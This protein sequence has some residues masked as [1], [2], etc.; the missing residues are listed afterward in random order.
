MGAVIEDDH[1]IHPLD[2]GVPGQPIGPLGPR[3]PAEVMRNQHTGGSQ[4]VGSFATEQG[5]QVDVLLKYKE[6]RQDGCH[7]NHVQKKPRQ[8]FGE[9][10][11]CRF[12]DS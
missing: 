5:V 7:Q 2:F 3:H 4:T 10:G 8:D 9:Q 11:Q 12:H 6:N 1:K